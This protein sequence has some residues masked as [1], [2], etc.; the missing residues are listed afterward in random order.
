MNTKKLITGIGSTTSNVATNGANGGG[1]AI[2]PIVTGRTNKGAQQILAAND[3]TGSQTMDD[4]TGN[5]A[6]NNGA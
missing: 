5:S 6:I 4:V 2:L 3:I 1:N